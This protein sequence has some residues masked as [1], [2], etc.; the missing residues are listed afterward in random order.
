M[1]RLH[2]RQQEGTVPSAEMAAKELIIEN[3][4]EASS[5]EKVRLNHHP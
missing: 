3:V 1:N 2:Q 5:I 4:T